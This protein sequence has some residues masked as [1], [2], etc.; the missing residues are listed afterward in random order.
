MDDELI[1]KLMMKPVVEDAAV[2]AEDDD[3]AT[4]D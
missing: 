3:K 1:E 4:K 2:A